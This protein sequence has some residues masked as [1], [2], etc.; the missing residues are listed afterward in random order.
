MMSEYEDTINI[1]EINQPYIDSY[2]KKEEFMKI[3]ENMR[4]IGIERASIHF[5]TGFEYNGKNNTTK[6]LGYDIDIS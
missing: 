6:T 1:T 4:F 2:M 3:L 5:I